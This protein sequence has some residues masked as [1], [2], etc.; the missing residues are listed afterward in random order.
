MATCQLCFAS[1]ANLLDYQRAPLNAT[2]DRQRSSLSRH[3]KLDKYLETKDLPNEMELQPENQYS[4][5]SIQNRV[6]DY[7]LHQ[8]SFSRLF[9][10]FCLL[11]VWQFA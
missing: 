2:F 1:Q 10:S 5:E 4:L 11:S 6:T 9:A 8:K 3:Q 7:S